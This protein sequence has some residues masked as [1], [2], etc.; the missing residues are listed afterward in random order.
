MMTTDFL[1]VREDM[2]VLVATD[3]IRRSQ[4]DDET[5]FAFVT[6]WKGH[7]RG[8]IGLR[9]LLVA[10]PEDLISDICDREVAA[11]LPQLDREEVAME[12]EKYDFLVLP[13]VDKDE[14]LLGVVEVDDV[15]EI[16]RAE[17]AEDAQRMVGAGGGGSGLFLGW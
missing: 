13:V 12:F 4:V 15:I 8:I 17:S 16:I 7:L 10:A 9:R 2:T 3:A 6:D 11:I 1:A 14:R 5:Q